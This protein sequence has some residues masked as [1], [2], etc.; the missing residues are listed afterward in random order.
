MNHD[1]KI[2]IDWMSVL[3]PKAPRVTSLCANCNTL[4]TE[5]FTTMLDPVTSEIRRDPTPIR[6]VYL[7]RVQQAPSVTIA[8]EDRMRE[9]DKPRSA[10]QETEPECVFNA[11]LAVARAQR[12]HAPAKEQLG[13]ESA[14]A[15]WDA[16]RARGQMS[17]F[18]DVCKDDPCGGNK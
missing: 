15:R 8:P 17:R 11:E 6:V 1:W 14:K 12:G 18:N 5:H 4:R 16:G 7:V 10:F 3:G 9:E 2:V 13:N